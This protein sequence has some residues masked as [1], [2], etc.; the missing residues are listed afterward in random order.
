MQVCHHVVTTGE[1]QFTFSSMLTT[2]KLDFFEAGCFDSLCDYWRENS[3]HHP[4]QYILY[5]K[6]MSEVCGMN[7]LSTW[8]LFF[9]HS[10][11][12][13]DHCQ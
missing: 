12:G 7:C 13:I 5:H 4:W 6:I 9:F 2:Y 8:I 11:C 3:G 10:A 1:Y